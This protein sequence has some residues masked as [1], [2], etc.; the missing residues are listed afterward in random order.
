MPPMNSTQ[1]SDPSIVARKLTNKAVRASASAPLRSQRPNSPA[2]GLA[3]QLLP[4]PTRRS[5]RA[6]PRPSG[7]QAAAVTRRTQPN[8]RSV[9]SFWDLMT[10]RFIRLVRHRGSRMQRA[11][12]IPIHLPL[13]QTL[14][15]FLHQGQPQPVSNRPCSTAVSADV[16]R[17]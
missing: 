14:Q 17:S 7:C 1:R 11:S 5:P 16:G 10:T 13:R 6:S 3:G 4:V 2:A 9:P 12:S 8:S 15:L